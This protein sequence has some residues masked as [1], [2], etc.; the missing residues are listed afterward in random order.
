MAWRAR[1][2][3]RVK[4]VSEAPWRC[5]AWVKAWPLATRART[6]KSQARGETMRDSGAVAAK[7]QRMGVVEARHRP[8][9]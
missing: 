3:R 7:N 1:K 9:E 4:P 5:S 2:A 8:A 6:V